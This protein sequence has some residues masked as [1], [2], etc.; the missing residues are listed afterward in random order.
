MNHRLK[1]MASV[2][3]WGGLPLVGSLLITVAAGCSRHEPEGR[4]SGRERRRTP[5]QVHVQ[6]VENVFRLSPHLYSGGEPRGEAAFADLKA[7]GVK[8]IVT[9]DGAQPDVETA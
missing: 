6:D 5:E 9:V 4:V 8:T 1:F 2:A 3:L 7:L